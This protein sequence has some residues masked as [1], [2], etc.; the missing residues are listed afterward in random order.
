MNSQLKKNIKFLRLLNSSF[1]FSCLLFLNNQANARAYQLKDL[2]EKS[3]T[4]PEVKLEYYEVEKASSLFERIDGETR[5]KLQILGGIGPNKSVVGNATQFEESSRVDTITYLAKFD[6]KVP[7]YA[8]NREGDLKK[9]ATGNKKVKELD[10]AKKEQELVKKIKEY[11]FGFQYASSLNEF[12]KDTLKDLDDVLTD[13]KSGKNKKVAQDEIT[14]LSVF[15][16]LAQIKKYEIEKGLAQSLLGLKYVAQDDELTIEQDYIEFNLR[17]IP[18]LPTLKQNLPE[19]NID[20]QK[21]SIGLEAKSSFLSSEKKAQLPIF[22][23]FSSFDWT[24]TNK[25]SHQ[26]SPFAYDPFNKSDFSI[27]VGLVW[28]IDFG[29]K[30]SNVKVAQIELEAIKTQQAFALKNLPIKVEKTYLDFIEAKNKAIELEKTY[31]SSKKLFNSTA[32]GVALGL[33]P[34]KDIIESYTLKAQIYQ[35]Y[36]ESVYNFE[37]KLAELSLEVGAELDPLLK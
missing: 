23:L 33:T 37:M 27:G 22:G 11:Y 35:Q 34:V 19:T 15:R 3:H 32:T 1:A 26:N 10:V 7:F 28:D 6:L 2:I 9:A 12:A 5:P 36:V 17:D 8:F 13:M 4:H 29:V 25:S 21:A 31:K 20:L 24:S 30:S 16:S 14:K 18:Q